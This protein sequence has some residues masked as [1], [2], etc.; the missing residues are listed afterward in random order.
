MSDAAHHEPTTFIRKY[1]FSTDHKII[2]LQY[3]ITAMVMALVAAGLAIVFRVQL[4][5]PDLKIIAPE[6]YISFVTMHGTLM[7]LFWC[8]VP[9]SSPPLR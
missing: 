6:T 9:T 8:D 5:W 7:L 4:A 3:I 2:G 1:V